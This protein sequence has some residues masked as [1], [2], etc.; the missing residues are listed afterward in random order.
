MA[1]LD[2]SP[3]LLLKADGL[4]V[5]DARVLCDTCCHVSA[6]GK[7]SAKRTAR[8][9]WPNNKKTPKKKEEAAPRSP[10]R[11]PESGSQRQPTRM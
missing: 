6:G 5:D 3:P 11:A 9:K 7:P 2:D 10:P 8:K 4:H 1:L